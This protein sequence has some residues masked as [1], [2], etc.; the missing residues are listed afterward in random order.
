MFWEVHSGILNLPI[1]HLSA[2]AAEF[3]SLVGTQ[4][5][6]TTRMSADAVVAVEE[7][8]LA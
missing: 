8:N 3:V 5:A 7:L 6:P 1:R 4:N 2:A